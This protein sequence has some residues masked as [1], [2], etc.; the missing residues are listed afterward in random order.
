MKRAEEL[1]QNYKDLREQ[2]A[3]LNTELY[4]RQS[5]L[6]K[7]IVDLEHEIELGHPDACTMV[8]IY[9]DLQATLR[10]RRTIKDEIGC[11]EAVLSLMAKKTPNVDSR[12]D[13]T[14]VRMYAPRVLKD[15]DFT[16]AKVLLQSRKKII[17]AA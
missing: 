7:K 4:E 10:E 3:A 14:R 8:Q 17:Q 13:G 1:F 9:K 6:D 15:L 12:F 2:A 11:T 16:D 5:Y